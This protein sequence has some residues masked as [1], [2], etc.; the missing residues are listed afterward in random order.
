MST[1]AYGETKHQPRSEC[2]NYQLCTVQKLC[3]EWKKV[4]L[5]FKAHPYSIKQNSSSMDGVSARETQDYLGPFPLP[6]FLILLPEE[7]NPLF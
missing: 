2:A 5:F 7:S 4:A 3:P 1:A 6:L